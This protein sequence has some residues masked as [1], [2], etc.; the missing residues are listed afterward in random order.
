M[1]YI[2]TQSIAIFEEQARL[3]NPTAL[4]SLGIAYSTGQGVEMDYVAAHKFFNLAAMRGSMEARGMRAEISRE[5]TREQIAE[6]QRQARA[7]LLPII[8]EDGAIRVA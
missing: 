8:Q 4:Y 2:D 3:G 7:W 6:A 5:M 1:A